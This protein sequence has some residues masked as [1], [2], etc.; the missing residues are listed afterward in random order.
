[1]E[2]FQSGQC[3][4]FAGGVLGK[5]LE[6]VLDNMATGTGKR[7]RRKT[8]LIHSLLI[9]TALVLTACSSKDDD[10]LA[11]DDTPA[12][13]LFNEGLALRNAG[14][15]SDAGKKFTELDKLYPYSEY[16]K[17]SLMNLAYINFSLGRYPETVTAAERFTTLY[18]GSEDMPYALYLIGQAYYRQIPDIS[19]DQKITEQAASALNELI[20]RYPDSEYTADAKSK[21]LVAYDQLAGKE[22]MVGRYYLEKRNYI[23]AIN[24]FKSVVIN[25]QTTRH[26]EEALARL[27]ESYYALGVVN[28]AQTAAAILGHNYPDSQW[29]KDSYSLLQKGGYEPSEDRGS[30][31]S[32]AFQGVKLF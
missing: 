27:T 3:G 30:W 9:A 29:Y 6:G 2:P 32:K 21:L 14:R 24:R 22:M 20:T 26:V 19:R 4:R 10:D 5:E 13:V 28:E 17:K 23:A 18:P 31:I 1:M 15:L 12:E 8:I 7:P 16:A 11:L 25:Y